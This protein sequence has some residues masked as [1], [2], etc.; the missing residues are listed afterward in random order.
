[1]RKRLGFLIACGVICAAAIP[2]ADARVDVWLN[3]APPPPR[4]EVVPPP[5]HGYVWAPG[6]W[7]WR[8]RRHVWIGGHWEHLH[9]GRHWV[10]DHWDN[11]AG[12]YHFIPGHWER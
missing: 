4:A 1:M 5:R 7:A 2:S 8:H 9:R 10:P 3:V 11:V 6:Y 12:R